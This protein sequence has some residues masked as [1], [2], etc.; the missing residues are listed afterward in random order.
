MDHLAL[1]DRTRFP[2][3]HLLRTRVPLSGPTSALCPSFP[4]SPPSVVKGSCSSRL[5]YVA[6][7]RRRTHAPACWC[8]APGHG[9]AGHP[10]L[11]PPGPC[12]AGAG[13][14]GRG[15]TS[16][17]LRWGVGQLGVKHQGS[18]MAGCGMS[19]R[20]EEVLTGPCLKPTLLPRRHRSMTRPRPRRWIVPSTLTTTR[21]SCAF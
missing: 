9:A 1:T 20:H 5:I 7:V 10:G 15:G 19:M 2:T 12:R 21:P 4:G 3:T 16:C 13:N 6:Y 14:G 11:P 17:P 8:G 18:C